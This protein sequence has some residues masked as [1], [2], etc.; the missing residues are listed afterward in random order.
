M[1]ETAD[2]DEEDLEASE[3]EEFRICSGC[4]GE[5]FLKAQVERDGDTKECSYCGKTGKSFSIGQLADYV[6]TA[7]DQHYYQTSTEP[8]GIEY[9]ILKEGGD[10]DRHG[11]PVTYVI[12]DAAQIDEKPAEHVRKVLEEQHFD[13]DDAAMG[14]ES[15]FDK[16][17]HY[18]DSS[19]EDYELQSEWS[20]F[21]KSLKTE[22][23]FFNSVGEATLGSV[24]E[25]LVGHSTRDGKPAIIDVGPGREIAAL[26]RARVFQSRAKLEI[27][28]K[29]PDIELGPPPPLLTSAGRMNARGIAVFYGATDADVALAETRPPVGSKVA[30]SRFEIIR[31][32]RLLD[33]EV[34]RSIFVEGSIFDTGYLRRLEKAKFLRT[35]SHII[36][37]P[38]MPDDEPFEYLITQVIA[39]YLAAQ[40]EPALDGIIYPSVQNGGQK[41]NV[42]LFHKAARVERLDIPHGTEISAYLDSSDDEGTYPDYWVV[43]NTPP[44]SVPGKADDEELLAFPPP[45]ARPVDHDDHRPKTLKLDIKSV[46]VHHIEKVT[47]G[48]SSFPVERHRSVKSDPKF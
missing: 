40:R 30:V 4:I 28:L 1:T 32:L 26:Y 9:S 8:T 43:E 6:D 14:E 7:F 16:E 35:L 22:S 31:P 19:V 13:F 20:N 41:K 25:N 38:V 39:D 46:T 44:E 24:F 3:V 18:E 11:E 2:D 21:Q 45:T 37:E 5:E 36:S 17:A 29:R 48:T 47:Y 12:A 33:I 10:W 34:L 27:A 42:V 15:K 23:R